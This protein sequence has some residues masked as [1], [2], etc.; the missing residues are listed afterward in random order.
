MFCTNKTYLSQAVLK[1]LVTAKLLNP[2]RQ[3]QLP[4]YVQNKVTQSNNQGI[5][6]LYYNFNYLMTRNDK[7]KQVFLLKNIP[8][9]SLSVKTKRD[10]SICNPFRFKMYTCNRS[11]CR[12]SCRSS[13]HK[14]RKLPCALEE[15]I[16]SRPVW[17]SKQLN[18]MEG[19][20]RGRRRSF[21]LSGPASS[22]GTLASRGEGG[23]AG[24]SRPWPSRR[25]TTA[26]PSG[27]RSWWYGPPDP[28][29]HLHM[30]SK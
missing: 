15:L 10:V 5:Y 11:S 26:G 30:S 28:S 12:R 3:S 6:H 9:G 14:Y 29:T 17:L 27:Y 13:R 23:G 21:T 18:G 24:G 16:E 8:C 2:S 20:S 1:M 19:L 25:W 4:N 7:T 22:W